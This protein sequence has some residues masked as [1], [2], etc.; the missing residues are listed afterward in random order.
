M[1]D[2]FWGAQPCA[3]TKFIKNFQWYAYEGIRSYAF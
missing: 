3:P 2:I 1:V